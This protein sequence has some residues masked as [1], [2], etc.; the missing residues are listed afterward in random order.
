M[1]R[2]CTNRWDD[3]A[4]KAAGV[5]SEVGAGSSREPLCLLCVRAASLSAGAPIIIATLHQLPPNR[6]ELRAN[7]RR[8]RDLLHVI[9]ARVGGRGNSAEDAFDTCSTRAATTR[10]REVEGEVKR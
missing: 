2:A 6:I 7:R 1:H 3:P 9:I 8:T 4:A 10:Q 5:P